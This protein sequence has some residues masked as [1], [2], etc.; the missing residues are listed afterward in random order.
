MALV[1]LQL[2]RGPENPTIDRL[3]DPDSL[4]RDLAQ[5]VAA[6][7]RIDLTDGPPADRGVPLAMRDASTRTAIEALR[8]MVDTDAATA[9]WDAAL[10]TPEWPGPPVWLHG[11]LAPGN[12]LLVHGRLSAVIDFGGLGVGDPACDLTVAWS[13]LPADSRN[14]FRAALRVDNA[15]WARARGWAL[16]VAVIQL[17]Y[18]QDTNPV[19]AASARHVIH[20]VLADHQRTA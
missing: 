10:Q 2:A 4:A 15:T 16:S 1:G 17:P 13:L 3:A 12:L 19:L 20:E 14:V 11:D 6:L 7:H 8:G 9:A 18:Y 5:F